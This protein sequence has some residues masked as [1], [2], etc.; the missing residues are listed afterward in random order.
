MDEQQ[1]ITEQM[2][3]DI[4]K[5]TGITGDYF[6]RFDEN[7]FELPDEITEKYYEE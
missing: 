4:R 7:E 1:K 5:I 6:T 2:D 3:K